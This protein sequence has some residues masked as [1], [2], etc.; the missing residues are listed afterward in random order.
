MSFATLPK[1][2]TR[3]AAVIE[4]SEKETKKSLATPASPASASKPSLDR[5]LHVAVARFT[6]GVPRLALSQ[7]YTDWFQHLWFSP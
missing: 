6:G 4:R 1:V 5:P 7:A 3:P 2:D